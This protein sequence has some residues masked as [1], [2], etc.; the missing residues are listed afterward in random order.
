MVKVGNMQR[1]QGKQL[2]PQVYSQDDLSIWDQ[3]E[4]Q[5]E[6]HPKVVDGSHF[7]SKMSKLLLCYVGVTYGPLV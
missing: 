7:E 3:I 4:G 2:D 1:H 6:F 5:R